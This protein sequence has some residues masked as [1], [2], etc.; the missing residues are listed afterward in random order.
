MIRSCALG[1]SLAVA[2]GAC[3]TSG[4]GAGAVR[5]DTIAAVVDS[6]PPDLIP[7]GK[8]TLRQ[9]DVAIKL[10]LRGVQVK[11]MPLDESVLRVLSPDSY[12]ALRD[13]LESRRTQ[14]DDLARRR[15]MRQGSIW[16]VQFFGLEPDARFTPTDLSI[17]SLGREYRPIEIL[18]VTSG[19]GNNRV[20]QHEM[21]SAIFLFEDGIDLDHGLVV[22]LEGVRNASWDATLRRIQRERAL[23]RGRS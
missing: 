13:L 7:P 20:R 17:T 4:T 16:Y 14:L 6:T 5:T 9:D 3:A 15:G 21:Q 18:P 12:R 22:S 10:Q 1:A 2:L 11:L 8:G 19:F 23:I